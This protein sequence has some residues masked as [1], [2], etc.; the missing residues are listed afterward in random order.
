M[1]SVNPEVEEQDGVEDEQHQ[2]CL[3]EIK[4]AWPR[5]RLKTNN[6]IWYLLDGEK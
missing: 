4:Y 6:N 1:P 2:Q 5:R 3:Y